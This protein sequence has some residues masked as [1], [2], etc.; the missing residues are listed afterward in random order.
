MEAAKW[1][2]ICAYFIY[3]HCSQ[4]YAGEKHE[5]TSF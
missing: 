4:E 2:I 3:L 5:E 1:E